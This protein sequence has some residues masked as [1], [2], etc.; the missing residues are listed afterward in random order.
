MHEAFETTT[1][2]W[3]TIILGWILTTLA[4]LSI[5]V[6]IW[7]KRVRGV[8]MCSLD[9]ILL[10]LSLLLSLA[11]MSLTTWAVVVEGQGRHQ[12]AESH[13]QYEL[14]ARSLLVNEV[15]WS[16][17]NTL[18]RTGAISVI[19]RITGKHKIFHAISNVL[20]V[21]T[22]AYAIAAIVTSLVIC[23]PINASWDQTVLG[24]CGDEVLAYI[25]LESIGAALD[26]AI[27]VAPL[28][29]LMRMQVTRRKKLAVCF[30]LSLGSV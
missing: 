9:D 23:Q 22:A 30:L 20:L 17:V 18:L 10:Y 21:M 1:I 27:V 3:L 8:S 5:V 12:S 24:R 25:C 6:Y 16:V 28:P 19:R 26:L 7:S 4:L 29:S 11:L 15:I 13:S 14:V 2:G